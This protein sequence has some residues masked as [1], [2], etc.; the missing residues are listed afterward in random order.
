MGVPTVPASGKRHSP[1]IFGVRA[2]AALSLLT[3]HVAVFAGLFGTTDFGE[4]E[5]AGN[6]VA[7]FLV[8]GLPVTIGVLFVPPAI[9]FYLPIA[10]SVIAGGKMPP[11][12]NTLI[13]RGLRLLPAYYLM[14]LTVLFT[15][16]RGEL[17]NFWAVLRPILLL[18]V[19]LPHPFAP[20]SMNGME[21]MWTVPDMIQWYIFLS[22][23]AWGTHRYAARGATPA[24]RAKR[25]M[26][27]API[28]FVV[29]FGWL[30][31]VKA[32][33]GD[34][35]TVFWWPFG[36]APAMGVGIAIACMIALTRISPADTPK[37]MKLAAAKPWI[38]WGLAGVVFL[39]N[40]FRPFSVI[41]TGFTP[42][43]HLLVTSVQLFMFGSLV[44]L[45]LIAPGAR[46]LKP[47]D[48]VLGNAPTVFL[49]KI[50]YGIYLWH[51]AAM[52]FYLQPQT[53]LDGKP[54]SIDVFYG[55]N[56]FA[57]LETVTIIGT[58]ILATIGYYLVERPVGAW[59]DRR[60]PDPRPQPAGSAPSGKKAA[61]LAGRPA[62]EPARADAA[63]VATAESRRDAIRSNLNDLE[64]SFGWRLL[65]DTELSGR[66]RTRW[67][68]AAT[69]LTSLWQLFNA[70]SVVV[71]D[72]ALALSRN[73]QSPNGRSA[74]DLLDAPSVVL[75]DPVPPLAER[76]ITDDGRVD[77]TPAAAVERMNRVFRRI[78]VLVTDVETVWNEA[79]ARITD[80][81]DNLAQAGESDAALQRLM[82]VLRSDPLSLWR[83][84]ALDTTEFDRL[85]AAS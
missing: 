26:L 56:G 33:G 70:Y 69:D 47:V 28:L 42:G 2:F 48:A 64:N 45:P 30:I 9:F 53:I 57:E 1:S 6:P 36:I 8:S 29:G 49:G 80:L 66:S 11:L 3:V 73:G 85:L 31:G 61:A 37:L 12:R 67:Q 62:P 77:L 10:R 54:K 74:A 40:C 58:V 16:N 60:F 20:S 13:R 27:P 25:L 71:Q 38:F 81:R 32:L 52:H 43:L 19:Y 68:A 59:A 14:Y 5:P 72:A 44:A 75:T 63:A 50:S 55:S 17:N 41:G 76:D 51:F 34:D 15:L 35:R 21:I 4:H 7:V 82:E 46:R 24:A 23:I 83:D 39:V 18:Q 84:G 79:T 78:A 65:A 22:L